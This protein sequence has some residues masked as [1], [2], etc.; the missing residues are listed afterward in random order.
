MI[1][2]STPRLAAKMSAG[3]QF[4]VEDQI[5]GRDMDIAL[6]AMENVEINRL[7]H[8]LLVQRHI[9]IGK[10]IALRLY[11]AGGHKVW[12]NF[13]AFSGDGPHLQKHQG[14]IPDRIPFQE[15]TGILPMPVGMGCG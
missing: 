7:S 9:A 6:G 14:K 13:F 15:K 8:A 5:R 1:F 12:R 2:T 4:V 3:N 11:G 10:H